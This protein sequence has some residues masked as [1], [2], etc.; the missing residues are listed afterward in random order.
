MMP[1]HIAGVEMDLSRPL[2]VAQDETEQNLR[3]KPPFLRPEPAHDAEVDRDQFA[4]VV[5]EQIAGMHVGMEETV[6]QSM[7]QETLDHLAAEHRQIEALG[8]QCA[9]IAEANAV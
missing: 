1:R 7:A 5:H 6:A 4:I 9:V 2:I 3:E 8:L